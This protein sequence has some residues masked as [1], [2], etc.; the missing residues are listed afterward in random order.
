MLSWACSTPEPRSTPPIEPEDSADEEVPARAESEI[1]RALS[2]AEIPWEAN[3][4]LR[5]LGKIAETLNSSTYS[6][7][8]R[9]NQVEGVYDFD[10]SGMADWVLRRATPQAR[11][12]VGYKL[13]SRP[14][15]RD[16][17]RAIASV[18]VGMTRGGWRRIARVD[19]AEPGDIVAWIKPAEVPSRNTGH[20][21][22][23][24]RTPARVS[25][26]HNAFF[27]RI[28]DSTSLYHDRDSREAGLTTGFGF[29][30]ILLIADD[31]GAPMAYGW[32]GTR[33]RVFE[34]KIAIGRALS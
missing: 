31:Q 8:I 10:C 15:A 34:T 18:P 21:G 7:T 24:V 17:H 29:G 23:V 1:E 3:Q 12:S 14:L 16:F 4:V 2:D 20:V 30:T 27:V 33:A 32:V 5:T 6:P 22:F 28:A 26:Y 25:G 13:M 11:R 9:V 19:E